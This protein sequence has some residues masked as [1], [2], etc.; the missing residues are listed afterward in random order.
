MIAS[1]SRHKIKAEIR[2]SISY[3]ETHYIHYPNQP[4]V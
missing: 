3:R 1:H 4:L 2:G